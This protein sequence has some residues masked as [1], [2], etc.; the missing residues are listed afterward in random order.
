MEAL[1]I[2][3][4]EIGAV[5]D[6]GKNIGD[7]R[8]NSHIRT[9]QQQYIKA[10]LGELLYFDVITNPAT[11]PNAKL[12]DGGTYEPN[13]TGTGLIL[14]SGIKDVLSSYSYAELVENNPTFITRGGNKNKNVLDSDNQR[15]GSNNIRVISGMSDGIRRQAEL[16]RFLDK[17]RSDYPLYE[18]TTDYA[19]KP[20]KSGF[21]ITKIS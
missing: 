16:I 17:N 11:V 14:F 8:I 20:Q 12:L 18:K 1:L 19:E 5:Y 15:Q 10:V 13:G 9:A 6:I 2:T 4:T 7:G 3:K 21:R